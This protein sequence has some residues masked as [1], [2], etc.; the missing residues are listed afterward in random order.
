MKHRGRR[1]DCPIHF[2]L[3]AFG[4]SWTLLIV[5]D[6]LLG[7]SATYTDLLHGTERIATNVLASRLARLEA[8]GIVAKT[9][10]GRYQLTGKGLDLFPILAEMAA[11]SAKHDP[12]S[13]VSPAFVRRLRAGADRDELLA[14]MRERWRERRVAHG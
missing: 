14:R 3:E 6:L 7:G 8:D 2:A 5:R 4:D 12:R 10:D 13:P 1:S 9:G 11:W